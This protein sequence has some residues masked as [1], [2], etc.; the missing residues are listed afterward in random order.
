MIGQRA[1]G[2]PCKLFYPVQHMNLFI[3]EQPEEVEVCNVHIPT[4]N[5][6][7]YRNPALKQIEF[8]SLNL[9]GVEFNNYT[10]I[11]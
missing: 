10:L 7:A 9:N 8:L 1:N 3:I 2:H 5:L 4:W 6:T 11:T